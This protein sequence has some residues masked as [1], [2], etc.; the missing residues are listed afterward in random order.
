VA[1][2]DLLQRPLGHPLGYSNAVGSLYLLASTAAAMVAVR[3]AQPQVSTMAA[4]AALAFAAVPW[5]NGTDT[6]SA[7]TLVL[8]TAVL[9]AAGR[10]R[11]PVRRLAAAG[12]AAV[13]AA[14]LVTVWMGA[15]Y[16]HERRDGPLTQ[17]VDQ[18]LSERRPALWSFALEVI[19][20]S[21]LTEAGP[22][23]IAAL[24][25]ER[26]GDQDAAWAHHELLQLGAETGV[27]GPVLGAALIA[28]AF[29]RLATGPGDA[30]NAIAIVGLAAIVIHASVDYVLHFTEVVAAAAILVG[31]G[32][33]GPLTAPT[34][35]PR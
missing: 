19:A 30:G 25:P 2:G 8:L 17:V 14:M 18:T 15:T 9:L 7:L 4:V 6:A 11:F 26:L 5:L 1:G 31:A 33:T 24:A 10:H 27:P 20:D 32:S 16:R 29:V 3:A 21:P 28:L 23:Q 13:S 12:A 35:L 22:G 34:P